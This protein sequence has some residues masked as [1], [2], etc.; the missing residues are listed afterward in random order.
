VNGDGY[1]DIIVGAPEFSDDANMS[2]GHAYVWYGSASG[3][4][5]I[6]TVANADWEADS[7]NPQALLGKSAAPAGD[8][9]GDGYDDIVIGAPAY[10]AAGDEGAAFVWFGSPA[11]LG[12][13]GTPANA[14]WNTQWTQAN[15]EMG[16]SVATAGDVNGDGYADILL[17]APASA[18]GQASEGAAFLWLGSASG[19]GSD[20]TPLNA[21]WFAESNQAG[22]HLGRS[23]GTA[24][25]VNGDGYADVIIGAPD[26]DGGLVNEGAAFI[27]LGGAADLGA[28]GSPANADWTAESNQTGAVFGFSVATA[29]DVT[30]DGFADVIVGAPEYDGGLQG[31]GRAYVYAGHGQ[32][33]RTTPAWITESN[34]TDAA[35]GNAVAT[36]GDVNGDGF[37]D[38]IVGAWLYNGGQAAEGRAYVYHGSGDGP[39]D[40]AAWV[41]DA[42]RA[43]SWFGDSVASAGDV[44]GDG[45]SDIL[46]GA[47]NYDNGQDEEGRAFLYAGQPIDPGLVPVWTAE[48]NQPGAT[49]AWSVGPAGDVNGDG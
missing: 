14:D 38:V 37:A 5:P 13:D 7:D 21:D 29:G 48:G 3:L 17:G 44:N 19:L 31:E 39:E 16:W 18:S 45:Y 20:G 32:G 2:E 9:N 35:Y 41:T 8:V 10:G 30:G 6:G 47:I 25:D 49:L 23:V 43:V 34:Q 40:V 28:N 12:A 15:A 46:V 22:A 1:G 24:G 42:N 33:P 26:Y 11:G 36:A 27:W 4:G